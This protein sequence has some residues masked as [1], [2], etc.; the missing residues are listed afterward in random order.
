[1]ARPSWLSRWR[2]PEP[3][4]RYLWAAPVSALGLL[5]AA[6]ALTAGAHARIHAGVL[7]VALSPARR[8]LCVLGG[9]GVAAVTLGHVIIA[10][11]EAQMQRLRT[12]EL[13][14]VAQYGRWGPVF[15]LA[16][17]LESLYQY[18]RGARPYIDNRFEVAARAADGT[19]P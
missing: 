5:C 11:G 7:E 12:H 16:Y 2:V 4:L 18:L 15:L 3:M 13:A 10:A 8:W 9:Q 6:A 1:M 14:H 19:G 17:P